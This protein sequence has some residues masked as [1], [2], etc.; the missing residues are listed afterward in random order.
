VADLVLRRRK[1]RKGLFYIAIGHELA[2][3]Q[4]SGAAVTSL[5]YRH[6]TD[7]ERSLRF[8]KTIWPKAKVVKG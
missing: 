3:Y 2:C 6:R 8:V 5:E 7:A 1:P 4:S